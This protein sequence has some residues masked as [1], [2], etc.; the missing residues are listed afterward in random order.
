MASG[1][2]IFGRDGIEFEMPIWCWNHW[3]K[4]SHENGLMF[5]RNSQ[6]HKFSNV[7]WHSTRMYP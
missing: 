1:D 6:L 7:S 4:T 3:P 5:L 2:F